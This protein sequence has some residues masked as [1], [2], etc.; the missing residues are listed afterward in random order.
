[1]QF[2]STRSPATILRL[3]TDIDCTDGHR[4]LWTIQIFPAFCTCGMLERKTFHVISEEILRSDVSPPTTMDIPPA[5]YISHD[6]YQIDENLTLA[7]LPWFI[8]NFFPLVTNISFFFIDN[9]KLL[10]CLLLLFLIVK[11]VSRQV[12]RLPSL[13]SKS[14]SFRGQT[15]SLFG[16]I[17]R[18]N[19]HLEAS[20]QHIPATTHFVVSIS[21][22]ASSRHAPPFIWKLL[23][24]F[25]S[26]LVQSIYYYD[27]RFLDRLTR[28]KRAP[29]LYKNS[30]V[31]FFFF[32]FLRENLDPFHVSILDGRGGIDGGEFL[33][34]LSVVF[35]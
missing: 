6:F 15:K 21:V 12:E 11:F 35:V 30:Y 24:F 34:S 14:Y 8:A 10:G 2:N 22:L 13:K 26:T 4:P 5:I 25:L 9:W 29:E 7:W 16:S 33:V 19:S 20:P 31:R 32:F 18:T 3:K 28:E 1:M 27:L 17:Y 23:S